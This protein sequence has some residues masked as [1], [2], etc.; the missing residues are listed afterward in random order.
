MRTI[1]EWIRVFNQVPFSYIKND[2]NAEVC[3]V[4]QWW[5]ARLHLKIDR[6]GIDFAGNLKS[7]R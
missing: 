5:K 2:P 4:Q 7:L 1:S 6:I 3:Q